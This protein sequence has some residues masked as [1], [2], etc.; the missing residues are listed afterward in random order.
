MTRN[1]DP[2][3]D[4]GASS[5][6]THQWVVAGIVSASSRFIPIP[7][8]DDAVRDQCRRFVVSRTLAA[9]DSSVTLDTL[10]PYYGSNE[11]CLGGCAAGML[12]APLKLLL[13][14]IRKIVSIATSFRN[15]PLEITRTVLMGRT[16]DRYLTV[17]ELDPD[18]MAPSSMRVAFDQ[19]FAYMDFRILRAAMA[20]ALSSVSGWKAAAVK[21]AKKVAG[22]RDAAEHGIDAADDVQSGATKIQEVL[23]RPET[24]SL[25][26]EFDRRFDE[27]LARMG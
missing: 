11:G 10:R 2:P 6:L 18:S 24:L 19:A 22:S 12:K 16:L 13:F 3:S 4:Q 27:L 20:D 7:L 17:H 9:H 26:D 25:F 14:P 5:W 23:R 15:V 1:A 8:I 21:S